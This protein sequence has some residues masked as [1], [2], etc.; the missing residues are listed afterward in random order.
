[1]VGAPSLAE[2]FH[3]ATKYT[4]E[5][6]GRHPGLDPSRQP[7][8]FKPWHEVSP[9]ALPRAQGPGAGPSPG[10][11]DAARLGRLL[12]HT[13]GVTA[14]RRM[15]GATHYFRA[16]PSAG[17]LYPTELYVAVRHVPGVPDGIH[18]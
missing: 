16:S 6:L 2:R 7:P 4:P 12:L 14:I 13:Y 1:M 5:R 10:P 11:L 9:L 15:Q 17:G 8:P 3:E 18:A